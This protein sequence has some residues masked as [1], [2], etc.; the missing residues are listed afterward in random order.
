MAKAWAGSFPG[1]SSQFEAVN[2]GRKISTYTDE[3]GMEYD[4]SAGWHYQRLKGW[5]RKVKGSNVKTKR[6]FDLYGKQHTIKVYDTNLDDSIH[7]HATVQTT[8]VNNEALDEKIFYAEEALDDSEPENGRIW[9]TDKDTN[10][11]GDGHIKRMRYSE[12]KQVL[13]VTFSNGDTAYFFRVGDI[14]AGQLFHF[15][16]TKSVRYVNGKKRHL[17]GITFW[18]LVRVRGSRT[19]ARF[20]FEYD[21]TSSFKNR[22]IAKH[23]KRQLILGGT[24]TSVTTEDVLEEALKQR[25]AIK[26]ESMS[27]T[28]SKVAYSKNGTEVVS[29]DYDNMDYN[30]D[31]NLKDLRKARNIGSI[32]DIQRLEDSGVV[33]ENIVAREAANHN[34]EDFDTVKSRLIN[35]TREQV[36]KVIDLLYNDERLADLRSS[37]Y[38]VEQFNNKPENFQNDSL[39]TWLAIKATA[40]DPRVPED[41]RAMLDAGGRNLLKLARF[42]KGS[43]DAME[44][45]SE[46][47]FNELVNTVYGKGSVHSWKLEN[48]PGQFALAYTGKVWTIDDLKNFTNKI[49]D[50]KTKTL[51]ARYIDNS[52]WEAAFNLL[53][54]RGNTE[55]TKN[56]STNE[57]K[58]TGQH[59]NF[60]GPYDSLAAPGV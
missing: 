6:F 18:D 40:N 36:K 15:A 3:K 20:P 48:S 27:D 54:S 4:L 30:T 38:W 26:S 5:T 52:D 47:Q 19:G 29:K 14:I 57:I 35:A 59:N 41:I 43:P 23:N 44:V 22:V 39:N 7:F 46:K 32:E 25:A 16:A 11:C 55:K 33:V 49:D 17:L 53:K 45:H 8:G 1:I 50:F 42:N 12:K 60:A 51:Y 9:D 21:Y 28:P 58:S 34:P 2:R 10:G 24:H 56:K 13:E 37:H 31:A